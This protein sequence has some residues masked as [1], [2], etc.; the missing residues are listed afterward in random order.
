MPNGKYIAYYRVST[1]KQGDSGLGLDAQK[2]AV[3]R[4]LNGGRWNL[5]D[6]FTEIETGKNNNRPVLAQALA[7]C[8]LH[9]ATLIVAKLDRLARNTKFL[10]TVVEGSGDKGVVFCDLPTIPEGPT[11]KFILTQMASVAELEAGLI[12]QRTKAALAAAK[13]RGTLLGR[14]DGEIAKYAA[15][16]LQASIQARQRTS[17]SRIQDILPTIEALKGAGYTSLRQL[18]AGLNERGISAPRGGE[19][20]AA[21]VQ[22]ILA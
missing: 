11:G 14:R 3:T 4:Y 15:K 1:Q 2:E 13:A 16:G 6:E 12:S 5:V 21:Q 9:R 18:A 10:L 22:R 19:W 7:A 8:R 17:Q 20:S